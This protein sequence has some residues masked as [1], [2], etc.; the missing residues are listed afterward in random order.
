MSSIGCRSMHSMRRLYAA[1]IAGDSLE[2]GRNGV[3]DASLKLIREKAKLE[4]FWKKAI[5][6]KAE[7]VFV[8]GELVRTLGGATA[9]STLLGVPLGPNSSFLQGTAFAPP[10]IREAIWTASTNSITE[11]GKD[12]EDVRVLTDVGDVPV[13]EIR[14]CWDDDDRL[15]NVITDS[16]KAVMD[17][18]P[19]RPLVLGGDHSITFP[20]VRAVHEKLGGPV[21][22]LH[23]GSHP[24]LDAFKDTIYGHASTFARIKAKGYARKLVQVGIRSRSEGH[25]QGKKLVVEQHE[26]RTFSGDRRNLEKLKLGDGVKGV[27]ISINVDCLDPAIAPGVTHRE[28]GGL[29]LRNVLNIIQNLQGNIVGGDVVGYNPQRDNA[30]DLTVEVTAKLVRELAAKISK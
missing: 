11:E 14:D 8:Q 18:D 4:A 1:K 30:L 9:T 29:S 5:Y 2:K 19:L 15:M 24:G 6:I 23:F 3:I 10:R 12:I 26:M 25:D 17:V 7:A 27:Y 13:Q 28:S 16:V 21:D 22:I 20:V